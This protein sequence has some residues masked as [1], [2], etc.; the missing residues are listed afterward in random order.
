MLKE[1][2]DTITILHATVDP[3]S[4]T[5]TPAIRACYRVA[6]AGPGCNEAT[7]ITGLV[8]LSPNV[9][10]GFIERA[11]NVVTVKSTL[12]NQAKTYTMRVTHSTTFE[13]A[14]ITFDTFKIVINVC[15]ITA[16][17]LPTNPGA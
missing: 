13:D 4:K 7:V 14:A 15:V 3:A 6:P 11:V 10:P 2:H 12:A 16:I 8:E 9:L 1:V 17:S 5:T